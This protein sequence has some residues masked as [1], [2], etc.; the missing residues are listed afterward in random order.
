MQM[1]DFFLKVGEKRP[2]MIDKF[3]KVLKICYLQCDLQ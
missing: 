1:Y 2:I 3:N